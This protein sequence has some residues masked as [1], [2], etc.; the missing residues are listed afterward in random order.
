MGC[1]VIS[2]ASNFCESLRSL[3]YRSMPSRAARASCAGKHVETE[4]LAALIAGGF[5]IVAS[6]LA[7]IGK[8]LLERRYPKTPE[9][10]PGVEPEPPVSTTGDDQQPDG[11]RTRV[12]Y[13]TVSFL[14]WRFP[15]LGFP[16]V[17][18]RSY[19]ETLKV[20]L[21]VHIVNAVV[22]ITVITA[23]R[24]PQYLYLGWI[25]LLILVPF[26]LVVLLAEVYLEH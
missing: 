2:G 15:V 25:A 17:R 22:I 4:I 19:R 1:E 8:R 16:P 24:Q 23:V 6:G 26:I 10:A 7:V 20:A 3:F 21:C 9:T 14:L 12:V 11:V 13:W 18:S 5:A